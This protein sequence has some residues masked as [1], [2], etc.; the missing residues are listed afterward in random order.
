MPRGRKRP[1]EVDL[2]GDDDDDVVAHRSKAPRSTQSSF[3]STDAPSRSSYVHHVDRDDDEED[4]AGEV[5]ATSQDDGHGHGT[6]TFESYGILN[7]KIVGIRY[8]NGYATVGERVVWRREP[9]NQ[10]DRNAIR[11]DNVRGEQIGHIPRT[12][13]AKLAPYLDAGDLTMDAAL[14]GERAFFDCPLRVDLFGT[15]APDAKEALQARM[16]SDRLPVDQLRRKERERKQR[17]KEQEQRRKRQEKERKQREKAQKAAELKK[18]VDQAQEKKTDYVGTSSVGIPDVDIG[19]NL[20]EL[21]EGA[22]HFNPREVAEAVERYGAGEEA[23]SKMPLAEQPARIATPLLPY[24]RQGLAWLL[25]KENPALP[26]A[27][28]QDAVQL[29][30]RHAQ[31]ANVFT[32]IA[33]NFSLKDE[34]PRLAS[35][36]ILADD[37]GLGKTLQVISLIVQDLEPDD[38]PQGSAATLI[39]SPLSVMSNWSGQVRIQCSPSRKGRQQTPRS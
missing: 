26:P 16:L 12:V 25:E 34:E 28:S 27:G 10:Y 6:E 8:Y 2:T 18:V 35:G 32:N 37:M 1:V 11:V 5:I 17:E 20:E 15:S 7:T 21:M 30:K 13:A 22:E 14:S 39:I 19:P 33:T 24:Q 23:L 4:A 9:G 36:A 38:L 3:R 31:K 29:W